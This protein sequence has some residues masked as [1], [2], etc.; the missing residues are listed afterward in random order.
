MTVYWYNPNIHPATEYLLRLDSLRK[1][2]DRYDFD[3]IENNVYDPVLFLKRV[4][5]IMC[6]NDGREEVTGERGRRCLDCY[7]M[8]LEAV[9]RQA[10]NSGIENFTTTLFVSPWQ[11]HEDIANAGHQAAMK[12]SVNFIVHDWRGSFRDYQR[13]SRQMGLYHQ[14]WCGCIF[15]EAERYKKKL[16]KAGVN[17]SSQ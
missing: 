13:Q 6:I 17:H 7:R 2:S 8:R 15:S 12:H 4:A 9:A 3:I 10:A 16:E 11:N 5:G 1:L 14:A